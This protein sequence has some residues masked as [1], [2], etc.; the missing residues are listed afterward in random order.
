[1]LSFHSTFSVQ[2]DSV[3]TKWFY[4]T[5]MFSN[6]RENVQKSRSIKCASNQN[7]NGHNFFFHSFIFM[8][9]QIHLN[10]FSFRIFITN[11]EIAYCLLEF[12]CKEITLDLCIKAFSICIWWKQENKTN[13]FWLFDSWIYLW[14][15]LLKVTP[16]S[17]KLQCTHKLFN[18][19]VFFCVRL[20]AATQQFYLFLGVCSFFHLHFF[21]LFVH[22]L[23]HSANPF[24]CL[25]G[26]W[27]LYLFYTSFFICVRFGSVASI[28]NTEK[29]M[30]RIIGHPY[31][32]VHISV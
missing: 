18:L 19:S 31:S 25:N 16:F 11:F 12:H 32:G 24:Q 20:F 29:N 4:F 27:T 2:I 21:S 6:D 13:I 26:R 9:S 3:W 30:V 28:H 5:E 10:L 22:S 23:V 8:P 1:M 7:I 15:L 17:M 14:Y